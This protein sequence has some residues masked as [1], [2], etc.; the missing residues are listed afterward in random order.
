MRVRYN[1]NKDRYARSF[2][3]TRMKWRRF[4]ELHEAVKARIAMLDAAA[5]EEGSA[6][7]KDV[8]RRALYVFGVEYD[9][10]VSMRDVLNDIY[11]SW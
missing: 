10:Q 1:R 8:G 5:N 3:R 4:D 6:R 9:I 7:I 11:R 2:R